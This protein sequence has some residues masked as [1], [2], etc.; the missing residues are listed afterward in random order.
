MFPPIGNFSIGLR[1]RK[2]LRKAD[3]T[4]RDKPELFKRKEGKPGK[5]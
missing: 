5:I 4:T 2:V 3:T 1:L